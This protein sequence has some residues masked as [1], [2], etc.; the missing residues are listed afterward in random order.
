MSGRIYLMISAAIFAFIAVLHLIRLVN[1]W[2]VNIGVVAVPLWGSWL[3]LII[4]AGLSI[5][6]FRLITQSSGSHQQ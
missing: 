6:A 4:A 5:W 1:Q 2:S 3:G